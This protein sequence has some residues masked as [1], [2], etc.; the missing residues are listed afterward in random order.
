MN[1]SF[2]FIGG[3]NMATAIIKGLLANNSPADS[4]TVIEP[5]V[6]RQQ[7][8]AEHFAIKLETTAHSHNLSADYV[9]LCVKPQIMQSVC[10]D[11]ASKL[12]A[13]DTVILSVAAGITCKN[14]AA[15][16]QTDQPLI[17][18][19]PNTPA[20]LGLGPTRLYT[21]AQ[22]SDTKRQAIDEIFSSIGISIW[23]DKESDIDTITA[24]SG[25]GPAYFFHF[26]EALHAAAV[27]QGLHSDDALNL[28]KQTALGAVRM[29]NESA[30]SLA[31]LRN[32]VTSKGGT[33]AAALNYLANAN[34]EQIMNGMV[35]AARD[36]SIE[37][38]K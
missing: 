37:L 18:C 31:E 2:T 11:L 30:A 22:L 33:T 20:L 27:D 24:V 35:K 12:Q 26:M 8:L 38:S 13:T 32:N 16:L 3:G 4:I 7:Y 19:M 17:R 9:L 15:W 6:E 14:L 1:H 36:R 29:A 28:V 25:S 5:S 23:A 21:P 10:E 34:F